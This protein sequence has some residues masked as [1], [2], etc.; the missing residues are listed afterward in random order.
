MGI[1]TS[2]RIFAKRF[3]S[4]S[5]KEAYLK[6]CNWIGKYLFSKVEVGET[7]WKIDK[8]TDASLPTVILNVYVTLDDKE[9]S[10]RTCKVCCEYSNLFYVDKRQHCD[11]CKKQKYRERL[12]HRLSV[13]KS[14]RRQQLRRE[15][16]EAGEIEPR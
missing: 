10:D 6:A 8:A 3:E 4:E 7:F 1:L 11:T 12:K 2:T 9:E 13:K 14:Y 5:Y 15:L 16:E